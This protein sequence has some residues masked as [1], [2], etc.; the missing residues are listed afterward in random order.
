MTHQL[1][2]PL[3]AIRSKINLIKGNYC[4]EASPEI[5]DVLQKI[6]TRASG[7]AGLILDVLKLERLK[8]AARDSANLE[9]VNIE[10]IIRKRITNCNRSRAHGA[11][12][13]ALQWGFC[14]S[15]HPQPV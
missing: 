11:L 9:Q 10:P 7:M 12:P 1:K 3:D 5:R 13:S 14:R 15:R 8:A 6:D 4:G 2:A